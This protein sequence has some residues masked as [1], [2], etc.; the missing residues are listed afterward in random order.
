[1]DN[2]AIIDKNK[3]EDYAEVVSKLSFAFKATASKQKKL[4]KGIQDFL[5][6][7]LSQ[8]KF[9]KNSLDAQNVVFSKKAVGDFI[10]IVKKA[11]ENGLNVDKRTIENY[12]STAINSLDFSDNANSVK[13]EISNSLKDFYQETNEALSALKQEK[14]KKPDSSTSSPNSKQDSN[15]KSSSKSDYLSKKTSNG[16]S[17]TKI[18]IEKRLHV[19]KISF[20]E[21]IKEN[22]IENSKK[23]ASWF[24]DKFKI[25]TSSFI[26]R[27]FD[28]KNFATK[29]WIPSISQLRKEYDFRLSNHTSLVIARIKSKLN[30]LKNQISN[31]ANEIFPFKLTTS[32]LKFGFNIVK[33]S[34]K[35]VTK[36]IHFGVSLIRGT[37]SFVFGAIKLATTTVLKVGTISIKFLNKTIEKITSNRLVRLTAKIATNF[38][39]RTYVGAYILGY[40]I[41]T[42]VRKARDVWKSIQSFFERIK[43][44]INTNIME[45]FVNPVLDW[46]NKEIVDF[47]SFALNE[48]VHIFES[49][50]GDS[51]TK[52]LGDVFD[53]LSLQDGNGNMLV[54]LNNLQRDITEYS[55]KI[56][57]FFSD[58]NLR[59]FLLDNVAPATGGLI[60]SFIGGKLGAMA[61]AALG[62]AICPGLGTAIGAVA[63]GMLFS[64][65]GGNVGEGI[66]Q[67]IGNFIKGKVGYKKVED[68]R[69][70][71][72]EYSDSFAGLRNEERK[73]ETLDLSSVSHM[74]DL[75]SFGN[76]ISRMK[77]DAISFEDATKDEIDKLESQGIQI[78][79][80]TLFKKAAIGDEAAAKQLS[81][82]GGLDRINQQ[83]IIREINDALNAMDEASRKSADPGIIWYNDLLDHDKNAYS[84]KFTLDGSRQKFA[85]RWNG[86]YGV[87]DKGDHFNPYLYRVFRA[88]MLGNLKRRLANRE[89]SV[90]DFLTCYEALL[91]PGSLLAH[92]LFVSFPV[93]DPERFQNSNAYKEVTA[94]NLTTDEQKYIDGD[95]G[96]KRGKGRENW[97]PLAVLGKGDTSTIRRNLERYGLFGIKAFRIGIKGRE[98]DTGSLLEAGAYE[99][100]GQFI[101]EEQYKEAIE[102]VK[103][104]LN[105]QFEESK[106]NISNVEQILR[107]TY[108]EEEFNK[109]TDIQRNDLFKQIIEAQQKGEEISRSSVNTYIKA[110]M[111][112]DGPLQKTL[113][114]LKNIDSSAGNVN[115]QIS[116]ALKKSDNSKEIFN[117]FGQLNENSK[118]D[119]EFLENTV[120][121]FLKDILGSEAKAKEFLA[122]VVP[123]RKT[124]EYNLREVPEELR[125]AKDPSEVF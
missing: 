46:F 11:I 115:E 119:K 67:V 14:N 13:K 16:D 79:S 37:F 121:P 68:K 44:W 116:E 23:H 19:P 34:I 69:T 12:V 35:T 108:S 63:G 38:I 83:S 120:I 33:A 85:H 84:T 103:A 62:T 107:N 101:T 36:T 87:G 118:E 9:L 25:K 24:K 20:D 2:I 43:T 75:T 97:I 15:S 96:E 99:T 57:N 122:V 95:E 64:I 123:S 88:A 110:M 53:L 45:K 125:K 48:V 113:N 104:S 76:A 39:F 98:I 18:D 91:N 27:K 17:I 54:D 114:S 32:I 56:L 86:G 55:S 31:F 30:I 26:M 93:N 40:V 42:V 29:L 109:L 1:M 105:G 58:F 81:L 82:L 74:N 80:S 28:R 94:G 92:S 112:N 50:D 89:I 21:S 10:E 66:G 71:F 78:R 111:D 4:L 100:N 3:I 22:F 49:D 6:S 8:T 5:K 70:A 117:L 60:G 90:N 73:Q 65:V 102:S 77:R 52:K 106:S 124:S 61:G 47:G 41:G 51:L 72:T 7:Y 59:N